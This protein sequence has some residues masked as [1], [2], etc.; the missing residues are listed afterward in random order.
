MAISANQGRALR[1]STNVAAFRNEGHLRPTPASGPSASASSRASSAEFDTKF[2]PSRSPGTRGRSR[3]PAQ[4]RAAPPQTCKVRWRE[5][6]V[7][8]SS[9]GLDDVC[10][11]L[12]DS[13]RPRRAQR[14]REGVAFARIV[15]NIFKEIAVEAGC[16]PLGGPSVTCCAGGVKHSLLK[17]TLRGGEISS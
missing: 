13:C 15:D 3:P 17:G 16:P 2:Q 14:L 1:R 7:R 10:V 11:V 8:M 5:L 12:D 9:S 4:Q 6:E